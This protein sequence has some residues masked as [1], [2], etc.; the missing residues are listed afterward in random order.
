MAGSLR[1]KILLTGSTGYVGKLITLGLGR[2]WEISGA[3]GHAVTDEKNFRCD[4]ADAKQVRQLSTHIAPDVIIHAAGDK[5]LARCEANPMDA[6]QAN[7]QTTLNLV[8]YFPK[9]RTVYISSDYVFSGG[10]G[11]YREDDAI[12]AI[13]A[14]GRTKACAEM[15]GLTLNPQFCVLRLSALYDKNAT[16][17]RFLQESLTRGEPVNCFE[18]A[19]YSPTYFGDFLTVL[20]QIVENPKPD[21]RIYHASGQRISRYF[22]AKLYARAA[23]LDASLIRQSSRIMEGAPF[24]FADLSLENTLTCESLDVSVGRHQEY[25]DL[26][27]LTP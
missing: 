20:Q 24:I 8:Q 19:F 17:F 6:Y 1:M 5:N 18:D 27:G 12:G 3:S 15:A 21:R 7:V 13:T 26:L 14:Y 4:L 22:F 2:R 23:N 11:G 16:F 10:R 9:V 25:L